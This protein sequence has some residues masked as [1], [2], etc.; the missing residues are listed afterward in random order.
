MKKYIRVSFILL[1]FSFFLI[2]CS[3]NDDAAGGNE[4]DVEDTETSGTDDETED[5]E[6]EEE[7]D[8]DSEWGPDEMGLKMGETGTLHSNFSKTEITLDSAEMESD[9]E[10]DEGQYLIVNMTVKN[11]GEE[12]VDPSDLF[13]D[14]VLLPENIGTQDMAKY[15]DFVE[16]WPDEIEVDEEASGPIFYDVADDDA[17]EVAM[18]R[19]FD[20]QSNKI[21]F[22][23]DQSEIN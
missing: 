8:S 21:S 2:A 16:A 17:Y 23:F 11:I 5:S 20:T 3:D 22:K 1:A 12:A 10:A 14:A 13:E 19:F 7:S 15:D 4:E 6:E 9:D 18:N